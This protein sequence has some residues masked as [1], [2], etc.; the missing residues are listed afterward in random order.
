[1]VKEIPECVYFLFVIS[2]GHL[3][4]AEISGDSVGQKKK[5]NKQKKETK[6]TKTIKQNL[7]KKYNRKST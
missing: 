6:E 5:R 4:V 2:K 1:M 3:G 7:K